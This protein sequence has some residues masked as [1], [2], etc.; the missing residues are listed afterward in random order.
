MFNT[1]SFLSSNDCVTKTFLLF[2]PSFVVKTSCSATVALLSTSLFSSG[3]GQTR[4]R[5]NPC[6]LPGHGDRASASGA[7]LRRGDA[8]VQV[9][10]LPPQ[11]R[12]SVFLPVISSSL[13][14]KLI[15]HFLHENVKFHLY[16]Y[17]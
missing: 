8:E 7:S 17:I 1:V 5:T 6:H 14:I 9:G 4:H 11:L 13:L 12:V 15:F 10:K 2:L 16:I 3:S